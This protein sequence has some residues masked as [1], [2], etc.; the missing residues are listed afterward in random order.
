MPAAVPMGSDAIF[1]LTEAALAV[2]AYG[3]RAI[4]PLAPVTALYAL[5]FYIGPVLRTKAFGTFKNTEK[6]NVDTLYISNERKGLQ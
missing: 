3:A 5:P 2:G 6:H 1:T 4:V